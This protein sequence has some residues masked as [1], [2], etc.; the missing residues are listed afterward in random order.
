[1]NDREQRLDEELVALRIKKYAGSLSKERYQ[2]LW[3]VA[4]L[5]AEEKAEDLKTKP[6]EVMILNLIMAAFFDGYYRAKAEVDY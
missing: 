2:K 5:Y 6:S 3:E 4:Y 1:M